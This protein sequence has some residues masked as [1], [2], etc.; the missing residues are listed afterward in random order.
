MTNPVG[1]P[2]VWDCTQVPMMM[3]S[4]GADAQAAAAHMMWQPEQQAWQ[5]QAWQP[6]PWGQVDEPSPMFDAAAPMP[7]PTHALVP[8][9][10]EL[11]ALCGSS[12]VSDGHDRAKQATRS[13]SQTRSAMTGIAGEAKQRAEQ[14][15]DAQWPRLPQ[16]SCQ[17]LKV[18]SEAQVRTPLDSVWRDPAPSSKTTSEKCGKPAAAKQATPARGAPVV[19]AVPALAVAAPRKV[20]TRDMAVQC[21]ILSASSKATVTQPQLCEQCGQPPCSRQAERKSS[22]KEPA[23]AES[24]GLT[25]W[26]PA[27][28]WAWD[29]DEKNDD[30]Q[31]SGAT[32]EVRAR[33]L[34]PAPSI[35]PPSPPRKGGISSSSDTSCP[36]D[37]EASPSV[38]AAS[39]SASSS[40]GQEDDLQIPAKSELAVLVAS[41]DEDCSTSA[42]RAAKAAIVSQVPPTPVKTTKMPAAA[43]E[44]PAKAKP[45]QEIKQCQ[46]KETAS[47]S[48]PQR[49]KQTVPVPAPATVP[50]SAK[51]KRNQPVSQKEEKEDKKPAVKRPK[52]TLFGFPVKMKSVVAGLV[53]TLALLVAQGG[54]EFHMLA[55]ESNEGSP[56][57]EEVGLAEME[58]AKAIAKQI[59]NDVDA[60]RQRITDREWKPLQDRFD[61][62]YRAARQQRSLDGWWV[63]AHAQLLQEQ[64]ARRRPM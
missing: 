50:A 47:A 45:T 6:E 63:H 53:V 16:E 38:S 51:S 57:S 21:E 27:N 13:R 17:T 34:P 48:A 24:A 35:L 44:N 31:H 59:K 64:Q 12:P 46:V 62:A 60:A 43:K 1:P 39:P 7:A 3:M 4:S 19:A 9:A 42:T 14:A 2:G 32:E 58:S 55:P 20:A 26:G 49:Q 5:Q 18:Q 23:A 11:A 28:D 37:G 54:F 56:V 30:G 61:E 10:D 40:S 22:A 15:K 8:K 29:H 52:M 41:R 33:Q 25:S 36:A